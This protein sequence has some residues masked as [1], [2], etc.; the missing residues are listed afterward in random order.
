[1]L[2]GL[3]FMFISV[4]TSAFMSSVTSALKLAA[5]CVVSVG[6]FQCLRPC[7]GLIISLDLG[8]RLC[9]RLVPCLGQR[10]LLGFMI[11]DQRLLLALASAFFCV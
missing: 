8:Q 4:F 2:P 10:F 1:M 6:C 5:F 11:R 3:R 7:L 9:P